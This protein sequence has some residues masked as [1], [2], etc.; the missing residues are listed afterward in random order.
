MS[1]K[2]YLTKIGLERTQIICPLGAKEKIQELVRTVLNPDIDI[3]VAVYEIE[4]IRQQI[5]RQQ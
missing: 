1:R 2:D 3:S 5:P 4:E